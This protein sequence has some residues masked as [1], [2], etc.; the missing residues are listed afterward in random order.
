MPDEIMLT[1]VYPA[2]TTKKTGAE[3][4]ALEE[5]DKVQFRVKVHGGDWIDYFDQ[6]V[7]NGKRWGFSVGLFVME[8]DA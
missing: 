2:G 5:H 3:Y 6:S 4:Y 1:E 8:T 7:P